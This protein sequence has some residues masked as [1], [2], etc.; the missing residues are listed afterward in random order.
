MQEG[1]GE[2]GLCDV[3]ARELEAG[4]LDRRFVVDNHN[5]CLAGP[6]EDTR[7]RRGER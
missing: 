6:V 2:V 4:E 3:A 5:L 1:G 7:R